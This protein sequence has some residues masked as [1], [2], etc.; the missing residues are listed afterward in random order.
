M[1]TNTTKKK[2]ALFLR[3]FL[4]A[5]TTK[6]GMG[7]GGTNVDGTDLDVPLSTTADNSA[8]SSDDKVL[9]IKSSFSGTSLQGYT[10]REVGFFADIA[11]DNEM[12]DIETANFN[13]TGATE[14]ENIMFARINFDAIGNF[15]TSDTIEVIYTME[16]E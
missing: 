6:L 13:M 1:I 2:V 15:S 16:V 10:V 11:T 14:K 4:G 12:G 5:G 9:E 8:I 3:E 7:G